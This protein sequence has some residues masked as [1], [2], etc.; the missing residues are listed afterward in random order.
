MPIYELKR[1][2]R[3]IRIEFIRII[4][5]P[6]VYL[7]R[8]PILIARPSTLN[9]VGGF[10][11]LFAVLVSSIVLTI[12]FGLLNI[13]IKEIILSSSGRESQFGFYAADAGAECALYWDVKGL[14][15]IGDSIFPTSTASVSSYSNI[16]CNN[17]DITE[18]RSIGGINF[19]A[20]SLDETPTA[21]TTTFWFSVVSEKACSKVEVSKNGNS[22]KIQSYGYNTCNFSDP[23]VIE[24]GIRVSY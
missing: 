8:V 1:M 4:R 14:T 19:S 11:A 17:Q 10:V 23:R 6:F 21:A 5:M 18:G 16:K 22:T 24:R 15:G 7:H 3:M 12:S 9:A 20:W 13:A 2:I